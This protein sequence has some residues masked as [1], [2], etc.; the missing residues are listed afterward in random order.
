MPSSLQELAS[1]R[2]HHH[3]IHSLPSLRFKGR[4]RQI[5][6]S[7]SFR[8]LQPSY[9]IQQRSELWLFE[10]CY[11]NLQHVRRAA[12]QDRRHEYL[13]YVQIPRER[14]LA[15]VLRVPQHKI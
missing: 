6:T 2:W 4:A 13:R 10:R 1:D 14:R 9:D 12:H 7:K 11:Y 5:R 8:N 3:L 15:Y